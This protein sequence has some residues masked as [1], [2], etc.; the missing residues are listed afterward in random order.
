MGMPGKT[1]TQFSI[2][3]L[4]L[5]LSR[6][7]VMGILNTTPDSFSDGGL[8]ISKNE[9]LDRIGVMVEEGASIIDIG[10]ESTRPGSDPVSVE[11]ELARISPVLEEAVQNHLKTL[12][13]I[14]TT[15]YDVAK[16][17]L[18][19]GVHIVNDVSGLR[20][21][22]G[23]ADLCA[24]FNAAFVLMHSQGDPKTMQKNPY[25]TDV[26]QE[27][28]DFFREKLEQLWQSGVKNVIVD[29]GIGFGKTLE[30]NLNIIRKLDTFTGYGSP[31]LVGASRKSMIGQ[32]LDD[33][34]TDGRLAGTI[35]VHYECLIKGARILRV[36][37]VK[38][39]VDSIKIFQAIHGG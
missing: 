38:E 6:P 23:F 10:G 32:I 39:A 25:Y 17:A 1:Y 3:D 18:E 22:P 20:K 31:L 35:A 27:I 19:L 15:K 16:R 21:E 11:E 30:H 36:H 13:S 34:L 14:D 9:A 37:D 12:F 33:R 29:P 4:I 28:D 7:A 8:F 2:R 26:I 24:Q 5:N